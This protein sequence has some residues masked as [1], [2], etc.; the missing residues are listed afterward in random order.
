[1]WILILTAAAAA[2]APPNA[3][4]DMPAA[5]APHE[6]LVP[7]EDATPQDDPTSQD[8]TPQNDVITPAAQGAES[9]PTAS[10]Y[11]PSSRDTHLRV[12][13]LLVFNA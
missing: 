6:A 3:D 10:I 5:P 2:A 4:G 13:R 11:K 1:M 8:A 7:Q 9:Q 12:G